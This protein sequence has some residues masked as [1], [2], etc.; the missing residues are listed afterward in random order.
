MSW[1]VW[2]RDITGVQ[3]NYEEA[4][5]AVVVIQTSI[6]D[7]ENLPA[8][9]GKTRASLTVSGW[10]LLPQGKDL[11]VTYI[12]KVRARCRLSFIILVPKYLTRS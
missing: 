1:L 8:Q 7:E 11:K 12:V 3:A 6:E 2:P 4:D 10:Q 9:S 5:G